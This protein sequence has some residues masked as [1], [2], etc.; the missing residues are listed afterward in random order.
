MPTYEFQCLDCRQT[1]EVRRC[2]SEA[3]LPVDC[4]V[5]KSQNTK[6][7]LSQFYAKSSTSTSDNLATHSG[8]GGCSGG[9]CGSCH[10]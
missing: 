8:C 9:S 6:K 1:F 4:A 10:H 7:L 5:C 3:D 2:F